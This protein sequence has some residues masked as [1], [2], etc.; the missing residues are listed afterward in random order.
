MQTHQKRLFVQLPREPR[1]VI[2]DMD[3]LLIDTIPSYAAAMVHA[4]LDVGHP[5]SQEYVLSLTGLLGAELRARLTADLSVGFPVEAYFTA[6]ARRLEPLLAA[7]VPL[8]LGAIELLQALSQCGMPLAIATSMN[9]ADAMRHLE[10]NEISRFFSH[11]VGRDD[12]ARGKPHPDLHLQAASRVGVAPRDCVVL[13]DSFN[14]VRAAHAA[15]AMT[16]MVPDALAPTD[17][18]RQ[19]C[20][21]VISNLH[22]AKDILCAKDR[23]AD[24]TFPSPDVPG[25]QPK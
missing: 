11:V 2:F 25:R 17:D 8:K 19:L 12:V 23:Q 7:K 18:I 5:I 4:G 15:G 16:I 3:G 22:A 14:G 10:V 9:R 20:V 13:E 21:V 1:A 24:P 6:M